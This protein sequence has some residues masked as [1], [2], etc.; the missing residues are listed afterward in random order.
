M[1]KFFAAALLSF[2]LYAAPAYFAQTTSPDVPQDKVATVAKPFIGNWAAVSCESDPLGLRFSIRIDSV[3]D[4]DNGT[5]LAPVLKLTGVQGYSL[6]NGPFDFQTSAFMSVPG[7]TPDKSFL[8][9]H[10]QN[11]NL[12]LSLQPTRIQGKIQ[13]SLNGSV[14]RFLDGSQAQVFVIPD[15]F[16]ADDYSYVTPLSM[17]CPKA[18]SNDDGPQ[19]RLLRAAATMITVAAARLA[20]D[21][22]PEEQTAALNEL[23]KFAADHSLIGAYRDGTKEGTYD[24]ALFLIDADGQATGEPKWVVYGTTTLTEGVKQIESDYTTYPDGHD[25]PGDDPENGKA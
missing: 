25:V 18:D 12:L 6:T 20:T 11:S 24:I 5:R 4:Q 9:L 2:A 3:P 14:Q 19:A 10:V 7:D 1:K 13:T 16:K 8:L 21:E 15:T 22:T 23:T 17:M